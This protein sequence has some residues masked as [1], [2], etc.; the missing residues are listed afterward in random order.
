MAISSTPDFNITIR[1]IF[2]LARM[3]V[4]I[5]FGLLSST[6]LNH[7]RSARAVFKVENSA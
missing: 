1:P 3:A 2:I 7:D 4:V 5:L 6:A